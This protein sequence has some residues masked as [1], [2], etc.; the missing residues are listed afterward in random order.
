MNEQ[1]THIE[2]FLPIDIQDNIENLMT[3]DSI[4]SWFFYKKT[5]GKCVY[6]DNVIETSQLVHMFL[7]NGWYSD[8]S[9]NIYPV[10]EYLEKKINIK[11]N[12]WNKVKGN[13]LF[14]YHNYTK[15][16]HHPIHQD[17]FDN[18]DNNYTFLYY[19]NDSDGDTKFFN[20][21]NF[22][23]PIFK[24][25]PKKGTGVL[26]SS[27]IWHASS[28]PIHSDYRMVINYLFK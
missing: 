23:E 27:K 7:Q 18:E 8:Y 17:I 14:P 3:D 6:N 10:V 2:N 28:N 22:N 26:F 11:I 24:C 21:N 5:A 12:T 9:R 13:C 19:V 25:T 16:N 20:K 4:F 15:D 1:I